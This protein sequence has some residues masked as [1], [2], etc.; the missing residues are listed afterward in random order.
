LGRARQSYASDFGVAKGCRQ[1][2]EFIGYWLLFIGPVQ[3]NQFGL[4]GKFF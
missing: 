3:E 4:S 1:F 2:M